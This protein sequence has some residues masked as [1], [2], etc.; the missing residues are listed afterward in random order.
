MTHPVAIV[1][2]VYPRSYL[3]ARDG[4]WCVLREPGGRPVG[5]WA[6]SIG[7]AWTSAARRLREGRP[8]PGKRGMA[9]A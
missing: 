8:G 3:A 9:K 7:A 2:A 4:R 5:C 1:R 6:K